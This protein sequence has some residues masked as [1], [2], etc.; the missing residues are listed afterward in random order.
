M[1][2]FVRF[3]WMNIFRS[4]RSLL[5]ACGNSASWRRRS[6]ARLACRTALVTTDWCHFVPSRVAGANSLKSSLYDEAMI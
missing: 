6:R 5:R 3:V 1:N 2:W 4:R